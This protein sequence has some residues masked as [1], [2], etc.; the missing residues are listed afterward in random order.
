MLAVRLHEY[1]GP[2]VLQLVETPPPTIRP[3]EVLLRVHACALNHLDVWNRKG[4][5]RPA[6]A[7]PRI[8]GSDIAGTVE[9]AGP[10]VE[11]VEP[12]RQVIVNPGVGCGRCKFCL[13]GDDNMCPRYEIIGMG[14]D[15]GYAQFVA[16]PGVNVVPMPSRLTFAE[17]AAVPLVFLTAWRMLVGR[18]RV[19]RGETVLVW[20]AGSGVGSAA[21]QIAKLMGARVIAATGTNEKMARA[22]DLGADTV[23]NYNTEDVRAEVRGLTEG[24]GVDVVFEHVGEATWDTSIKSLA[25]GGRLVTCGNTTGWEAATD[26]RYVFSRQLSIFGSFMGSKADLLALLPWIE[27]GAL[28]PVVH[29]VLP[30]TEAATAH[31]LLEAAAQFGKIVLEPPIE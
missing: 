18:A 21:I 19:A 12:G 27:D 8:L 28:Q 15:G 25:V 2:E 16:V 26:L 14:R 6:L 3:D 30:L 7:L 11:H 22:H 29:K 9:A 13:R 20:G 17:A 31:R 23:L 10:L 24:R 4:E 5:P 1:G